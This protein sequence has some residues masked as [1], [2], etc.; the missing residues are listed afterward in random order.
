MF[1][2]I[3]FSKL[4][5]VGYTFFSVISQDIAIYDL[6][7]KVVCHDVNKIQTVRV[8]FLGSFFCEGI[9]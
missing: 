8:Y 1:L 2:I 7:S 3:F 6:M 5:N 9:V 4:I